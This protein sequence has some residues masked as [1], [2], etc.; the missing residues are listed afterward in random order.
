MEITIKNFSNLTF[1]SDRFLMLLIYD[2]L[3][4][5][6]SSNIN[7]QSFRRQSGGPLADHP[8]ISLSS[9]KKVLETVA[10]FAVLLSL[11]SFANH[12]V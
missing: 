7:E 10:K 5:Y 6:V 1:S 11:F 9:T 4:I 2:L 8:S 12:F 3:Y